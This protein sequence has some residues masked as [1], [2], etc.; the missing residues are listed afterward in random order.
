MFHQVHGPHGQ[1]RTI[2]HAAD[3]AVEGHVIQAELR[4][5][6]FPRIFLAR[7]LKG[8]ELGLAIERIAVDVDLGI[9]AMNLSFGGDHKRVDLEERAVE[10]L[11]EFRE[12]QEER[13]ELFD[14]IPF[15]AQSEGELSPL[16]GLS[17]H[18]GIA[19]HM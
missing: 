11:E 15:K 18:G 14:L 10:L 19:P 9:E 8:L 17:A 3:G 4:R 6:L 13:R 16:V 2:D 7:I 5:V 1:A 12:A